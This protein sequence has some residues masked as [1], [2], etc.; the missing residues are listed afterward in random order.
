MISGVLGDEWLYRLLSSI[1]HGQNWALRQIGFIELSKDPSNESS[2]VKKREFPEAVLLVSLHG[3][4][5]FSRL[6][7]N[8]V[9]YRQSDR[10]AFEELLETTMDRLGVV[11]A[12]RFWRTE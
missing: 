10:L 12:L 1:A 9:G 2:F 7:W 3:M 4:L 6:I 11:N 5:A 8:T